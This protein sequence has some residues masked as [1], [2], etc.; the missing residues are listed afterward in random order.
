MAL[1]FE[2]IHDNPAGVPGTLMI[3]PSV[4]PMFSQQ[5]LE[6]ILIAEVHNLQSIIH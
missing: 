1:R 4:R 5:V 2:L 6:A 3:D